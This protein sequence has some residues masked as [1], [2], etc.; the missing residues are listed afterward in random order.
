MEDQRGSIPCP[1]SLSRF[2][3]CKSFGSVIKYWKHIH[4]YPYTC[5]YSSTVSKFIWSSWGAILHL[6][7]CTFLC[8][9]QA[10][11]VDWVWILLRMA[12]FPEVLNWHP[13]SWIWTAPVLFRRGR[14][15]GK[16]A[17]WFNWTEDECLDV[18]SVTR[19]LSLS[20]HNSLISEACF[21]HSSFLHGPWWHLNLCFQKPLNQKVFQLGYVLWGR[22]G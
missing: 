3:Y 8:A 22:S 16:S 7:M 11:V 6:V 19:R 1:R 20:L 17:R 15:G 18:W 13:V 4:I 10:H 9:H 14:G 2:L 5:E 21:T 12:A